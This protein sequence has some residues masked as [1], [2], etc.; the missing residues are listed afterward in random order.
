MTEPCLSPALRDAD[1]V[2]GELQVDPVTGLSSAEAA[3]RLATDGRN[4]LREKAPEGWARAVLRQV[5][6]PLVLLLLAAAAVST[7]AWAAEGAE[8][9]PIDGIVITVIVILN[10]G[11]GL[12]QEAKAASAVAALSTVTAPTS[13]VLRDGMLHTVPTAELVVG[14]ILSLREGDQVGADAR[15]LSA[16][17][18]RVAEASLT[19]ESDAVSKDPATLEREAPLAEQRNRVFA[20]T[21]VMQG[22]GVA[23]IT[24]TG[25]DTELGSIAR[26][27]DQTSER[28]TPLQTE[29][30]QIGSLLGRIVVAIAVI[31]MAA[32]ILINGVHTPSDL[33][34]VLLLGVSLAV[35]AVPEGLPAI[36]SVVLSVGVQ[37]M[38][39]KGAVVT[40]LSS[41]E[42]L[43]GAS[44]I[45]TD[46]TGTLT[47]GEM[48][49]TRVVTA[50]G[51]VCL[52]GTGYRPEGELSAADGS[53]VAGALAGEARAVLLA[54]ALAC[55]AQLHRDGAEWSIEGD[56]T[57][58]AFVVAARKAQVHDR[59]GSFARVAEEPFTS[60]RKMMSVVV[61]HAGTATLFTK[62]APDILLDACRWVRQGDT[63]H[64]L[65]GSQRE[66]IREELAELTGAGYRTLGTAY[67]ELPTAPDAAGVA[68]VAGVAGGAGVAGV[69]ECENELVY[70]GTVGIVDPPREEATA[71]I[72]RAHAAGIRVV[73]IT[74]DHPD[75][76]TTIAHQLGLCGAGGRAVTGAEL[77]RMGEED[78]RRTV[79]HTSVFAR[80]APEHKLR[81]VRALQQDGSVVA[82]TGD[83]VNDAPALKAAD[84]GVAMGI[85]GTEVTKSAA[86]MILTDD[87]FATIVSAVRQGRA[88][89]DNIRKFL[90]YLLSSNMGEVLTVFLGVVGASALG[91]SGASTETVVL[92]LL[93]TQILW[94]NL[95]TDS[96]PAF[97]L[98]IDP[99]VDDVMARPPR[100]VGE[101]AIDRRMWGGIL[102]VGVVMAL[103]SL[104]A[105]DRFLPGGFIEGGDSLEVARTA[106][107]TTL[108][109]AQ[110]FNALAS[111]SE[112]VSAFHRPFH[113]RWLWAS[114]GLGVAL[115][116]AVVQ[117]PLLHTAFGTA[118]LDA[119]HWA[120]SIAYASA[121]LW[122]SEL[123]KVVLRRRDAALARTGGPRGAALASTAGPRGVRGGQRGARG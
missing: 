9:A 78:M 5:R 15:L 108:V 2:T 17:A 122:F 119:A 39:R 75:T 34:L 69:A 100:A 49:L 10:A 56:P 48:T 112:T 101:R 103:A 51:T 37:R 35:A 53:P 88:I 105:L 85:T 63:R 109:F 57:E 65:D 98:G 43:G 79:S 66:R 45:C 76:A 82:M 80:V 28:P 102:S 96:G 61:E 117:L 115:Q 73:M 68:G 72:A 89:F 91:L 11:L 41:V 114:L 4:V 104:A 77:D 14:D 97:A 123:R 26:L 30:R 107:F 58:A 7:L 33:V 12:A 21:A 47:R 19:G 120:T 32:I 71:A 18:L 111:R 3:R 116:I 70:L 22:V 59:A 52:S 64:P 23:V 29:V 92:P 40:T 55:D 1:T 106:A 31:V 44:V 83:G 36:L 60:E 90:R 121:V 25:M 24:A 95:I 110:L 84:I 54:G 62:G 67:R 94:I 113:N 27:L 46:K 93:A 74:G 42:A 86:R 6:E 16:T 13:T 118:P 20:G 99:E 38:A 81:L 8:G 50:S 87:N